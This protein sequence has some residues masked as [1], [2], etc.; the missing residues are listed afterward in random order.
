ME[1]KELSSYYEG[2]GEELINNQPE[3]AYLKGSNIKIAYLG[4][5]LIKKEGRGSKPV[6]AE[7]EIIPGKYK[8]GIE[9]DAAITFYRP[10]VSVLNDKQKQILVFQQL[11]KIGVNLKKDADEQYVLNEYD[12]N[13]FKIIID[14]FGPNWSESQLELFEEDKEESSLSDDINIFE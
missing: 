10:N 2:I 9:A 12:V 4:S 14:K 5:D 7:T 8:W 13:D 1:Q 11:L 6:F 3:L